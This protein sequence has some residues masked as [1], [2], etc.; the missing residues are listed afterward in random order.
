MSAAVTTDPPSPVKRSDSCSHR[1]S[2]SSIAEG[3]LERPIPQDQ[4][5]MAIEQ[6][7][8]VGDAFDG[9][10]QAILGGLGLGLG[11]AGFGDVQSHAHEMIMAVLA[12]TA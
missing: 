8:S 4:P 2:A 6:D 7:E 12:P 9:V 3:V 10:A 11:A 5:A 1:P